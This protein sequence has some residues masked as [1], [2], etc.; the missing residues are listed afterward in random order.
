M[1]LNRGVVLG[2][3]KRLYVFKAPKEMGTSLVRQYVRGSSLK[4]ASRKLTLKHIAYYKST[5]RMATLQFPEKGTLV[6]KDR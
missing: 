2:H 4:E 6:I 1:R 5:G 3:G